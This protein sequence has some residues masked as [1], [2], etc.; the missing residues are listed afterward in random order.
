VAKDHP[1][2]VVATA[3]RWAA[4]DPPA[5]RR[6]LT[7]AL[8]TLVKAGNP[9]AL[10]VLGFTTAASLDVLEFTVTPDAVSMGDHI[11]LEA[12]LRSTAAAEQHLVVDFVIHHVNAAGG[13]SPKVFKWKTLTIAPGKTVVLYKRRMIQQASTRTYRAGTHRVEL[14]VA[15]TVVAEA[16]FDVVV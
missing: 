10:E 4:E 7:H 8:R 3:R 2:V 5:D 12:H 15:G 13:T 11:A 16:A 14:Q 9:E 6:M 1:D